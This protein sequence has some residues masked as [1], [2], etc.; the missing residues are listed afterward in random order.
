MFIGPPTNQPFEVQV[1]TYY[2]QYYATEYETQQRRL[3]RNLYNNNQSIK[4]AN[5][6]PFLQNPDK[7]YYFQYNEGN[8]YMYV[9]T[10]LPDKKKVEKYVYIYTQKVWCPKSSF[11][12]E[13]S[14]D[15]LCTKV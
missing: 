11:Y 3:L 12:I 5:Q 13:K 8:T 4:E 2:N 14:K 10:T 6:N 1:Y 7:K 9:E 15:I